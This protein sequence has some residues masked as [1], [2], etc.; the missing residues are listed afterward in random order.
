MKGHAV[1]FGAITVVNAIPSGK[2]ATIG[3]DLRTEA[4][5][6]SGGSKLI[7]MLE[8]QEKTDTKLAETCAQN[9]HSILGEKCTGILTVRSNIP[10]S[11]GLKSSSSAANAICLAIRNAYG[12]SMD[13][14]DVLRIGCISSVEA[15]V[16]LT[17]AFDDAC[18]CQFGGFVATDNVKLTIE[19]RDKI[20]AHNVLLHIPSSKTPKNTIRL[21]DFKAKAK[22]FLKIWELSKTEPFQAMT[23]NGRMVAEILN[24]DTGL[25]DRALAHGALAAGITGTGPAVAIIANDSVCDRILSEEEGFFINCKTRE[26]E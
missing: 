15:G 21:Q 12:S 14:V 25:T 8:G 9:M 6:E 23:A 19:H 3:I 5:F 2:G 13:D 10:V 26:K 7:I 24:A 16:S 18:G 20:G 1:S 4:T 11:R 17:G 22:E